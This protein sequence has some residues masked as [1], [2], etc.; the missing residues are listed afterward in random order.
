MSS[1]GGCCWPCWYIASALSRASRSASAAATL[2][3]RCA[4]WTTSTLTAAPTGSRRFAASS[5]WIASS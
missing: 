3:R 2:Q 5:I 1:A 4:V